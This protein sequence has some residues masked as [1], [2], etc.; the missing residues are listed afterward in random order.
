MAE[1]LDIVQ[2]SEAE[3]GVALKKMQAIIID[4]EFRKLSKTLE[5]EEEKE[6]NKNI[7]LP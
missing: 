2:A 7:L 6:R 1:I 3:I 5:L 4:G